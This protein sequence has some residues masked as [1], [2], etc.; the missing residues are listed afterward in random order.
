MRHNVSVVIGVYNAESFIVDTLAS[1]Q[2][3]TEV[4]LEVVVIDDG[5]TDG[6]AA[7]VQAWAASRAP[8]FALR[9][10]SQPNGGVAAAKNH[11][12][13][14]AEGSWIAFLDADDIWEP[15]HLQQL[16]AATAAAP[17]AVASYGAG[18]LLVGSELSEVAYDDFW[19]NPSKRFGRPV[20]GTSFLVLDRSVLP[21][22]V[23]G[24]FI[25]P[26]SLMVSAAALR[27]VGLFNE[28]LGPAEDREL[29]VRLLLTGRFVYSPVSITRYRW[30]ENNETQ[31]KNAKRI[32]ENGLRAI[33]M[34]EHNRSLGLTA[35]EA[36]ACRAMIVEAT[37]DYL[38]ACCLQG[39][40]AYRAGLGFVGSRFGMAAALAAFRP[41]HLAR[42]LLPRQT[43]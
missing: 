3:Q 19:D 30:H 6:T 2:A 38:S 20:G 29:L 14:R 12:I 40:G 42:C 5:S 31:P 41:R 8:D 11:G 4:P 9:V 13:R 16:F 35:D 22:L 18:R 25:K 1:V 36:A 10:F 17:D 21:R 37:A 7:T 23:K 33:Q 43:A 15:D 39:L 28:S 24:N 32:M 26:S 34:I 27:G